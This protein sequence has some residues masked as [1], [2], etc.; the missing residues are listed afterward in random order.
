[1]SSF[2][3]YFWISRQ[4]VLI[5]FIIVQQ[6]EAILAEVKHY[7]STVGDT[8]TILSLIDSLSGLAS[9]MYAQLKEGVLGNIQL[10]AVNST[11]H[12]TKAWYTSAERFVQRLKKEHPLYCDLLEPFVAGV[13]QVR[14]VWT[15]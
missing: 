1:M 15:F 5:I 14:G 13:S 3:S 10:N 7:V 6:F 8:S 9:P 11:L 12:Q 4:I 2:G